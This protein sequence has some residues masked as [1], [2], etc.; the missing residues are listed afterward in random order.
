MTLKELLIN[1]KCEYPEFRLVEKSTSKLMKVLDFL[2]KLIT[3]WRMKNFMTSFTTTLGFVVYTPSSW[4]DVSE[5]AKIAVLR[6][7]R[8]HMRQKDQGGFWFSVKYLLLPFP[9]FWAYYRMKYEMEAYEVSM[10][11]LWEYA[12]SAAFTAE[13]KQRML[14]HF[15]SAEYF[16]TWPWKK[17]L[18]KWYDGVVEQMRG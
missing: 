16:W 6:H 11:V 1:I 9:I 15:T 18:N 4:G 12:G 3:L 17:S 13:Y 7:E 8:V 5:R 14:Q 2:L 10:R